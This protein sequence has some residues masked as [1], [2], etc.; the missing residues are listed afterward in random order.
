M[1]PRVRERDPN[2]RIVQHLRSVD[3]L[4]R[5]HDGGAV[6]DALLEAGRI[7]ER[8]FRLAALDPLRAASLERVA[9]AAN[10][11]SGDARLDARRRIGRA[12]DALG[13]STSPAGSCAW[14]VLGLG[15]TLRAWALGRGWRREPIRQETAQGILIA[16]LGVLAAHYGL[17]FREQRRPENIRATRN[18]RKMRDDGQPEPE[19]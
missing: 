11:D 5:L 8:G 9:G 17:M 19:A 1:R 2:G 4:Q 6:D 7:F 16:A 12:L 14:H 10:L 3:T 15:E 13:G 18:S